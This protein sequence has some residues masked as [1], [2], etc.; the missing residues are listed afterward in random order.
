M[1]NIFENTMM[2]NSI[3]IKNRFSE[4][5]FIDKEKILDRNKWFGNVLWKDGSSYIGG[6]NKDKK[7]G[8]G[9][10]KFPNGYTLECLWINDKP[11]YEQ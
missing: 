6:F 7:H 3:S 8:F 2:I 10:Y 4:V 5:V 1:E 9:L 11:K